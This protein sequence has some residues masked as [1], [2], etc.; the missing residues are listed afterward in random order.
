VASDTA[1]IIQRS[2]GGSQEWTVD[3]VLLIGRDAN[4]DIHLPDRQVSRRH[5][6][7]RR[8]GDGFYVEDQGSKNGTWLNGTQ[9]TAPAVLSD[10]DEISIAAR[11]KLFFVDADA[12]APLMF[13][14]KGLRIAQETMAVFVNGEELEPPLS[15]PQW[16]L[17]R[18][19]Y[20]AGGVLVTREELI[21][22]VWPDADPGGVS[23]DA[24]DALV[25]RVRI[26]LTEADP[27]HH[28]IVTMRGY[29]FRLDNV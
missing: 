28:Y 27:D 19:L 12:T 2:S 17:V 9:V 5:A 3:D 24:L 4:C 1:L 10:G 21:S 6:T 22:K 11:F 25:R 26:R 7:I 8:T 29:G 15:G 13:E 14:G 18:V 20:E 23:E 16:E